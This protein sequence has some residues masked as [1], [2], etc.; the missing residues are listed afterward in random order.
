M[1]LNYSP[2]P[3]GPLLLFETPARSSECLWVKW[4]RT[5]FLF[6]SMQSRKRFSSS[7]LSAKELAYSLRIFLIFCFCWSSW[8]WVLTTCSSLYSSKALKKF[9]ICYYTDSGFRFFCTNSSIIGAM[10]GSWEALAWTTRSWLAWRFLNLDIFWNSRY[11]YFVCGS[12]MAWLFSKIRSSFSIRAPPCWVRN[13]L[14]GSL[15]S[16]WSPPS[17][18]AMKSSYECCSTSSSSLSGLELTYGS[19]GADL[20]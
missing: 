14:P 8:L 1:F 17:S 2:A 4:R 6:S 11:S 9:T 19:V 18:T 16:T 15:M 12:H 5:S 3:A 13:V 20:I 10:F 7:I